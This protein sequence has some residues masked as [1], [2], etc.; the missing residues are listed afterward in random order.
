ML[1]E[2]LVDDVY[3]MITAS[4]ISITI[5]AVFIIFLFVSW[6][7]SHPNFDPTDLITGDNGRISGTKCLAIG[8]WLVATWGFVTMVQQ[9]R[10][11]EWYFLSYMGLCL[12]LKSV[13]DYSVT[14]KEIAGV[15]TSSS[16]AVSATTTEK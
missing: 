2:K 7:R 10:L 9:G 15:T 6:S 11:T 1:S 3:K 12:G 13:K 16:S 14:K 8:G 4:N 5:I